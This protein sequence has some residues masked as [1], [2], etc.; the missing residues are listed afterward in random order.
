M[1]LSEHRVPLSKPMPCDGLEQRN[2]GNNNNTRV[3]TTN[4]RGSIDRCTQSIRSSQGAQNTLYRVHSISVVHYLIPSNSSKH[5]PFS[6]NNLEAILH[7]LAF[8][9]PVYVLKL[10]GQW[11]EE[12][13]AQSKHTKQ[14]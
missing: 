7:A 2:L 1:N 5:L 6:K 12:V 10:L 13:T 3:S 14:S 11:G 4:S 8:I 9:I